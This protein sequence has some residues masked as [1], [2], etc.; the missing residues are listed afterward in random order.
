MSCPSKPRAHPVAGPLLTL[1]LLSVLLP[2]EKPK[3]T[4]EFRFPDVT[5]SAGL[6][7][8]H[9]TGGFG[10]KYLPETMGS[11]CLFVD[12][13]NDGWPEILALNGSDLA[14]PKG[15]TTR[16]AYYRNNRDGTFI[17]VTRAAGLGLDMY[18]MGATAGDFDNDGDQDIYITC[19]GPDHLFQNQ[20]NGTFREITAGAGLGNPDFGASA[21]WLD[22]DRD[23]WLDLYV[24]NYVQW[25]PATDIYC[26]LDGKNKSYCT[27]E[28]YQGVSGR[29]YR[30]LQG[31]RFEDVTR[32]AGLFLPSQKGLGVCVTDL[33][34]DG[35]P[36]IVVANDTQ[37][38]NVFLNGRNG[39]FRDVGVPSGVAFSEDGV[40]RGAMGIDAAD[41]DLTGRQSLLIGNFSNQ[42]LALY[43][44]EGNVFF[45][46]EAP[47]SEV[48]HRSLLTLAFGCFFFDYDLDGLIDI[49]VANGHV[50]N[51]INKVQAK[52][53]YAQPPHLFRNTGGRAFREVTA[54][55]GPDLA[56]PYVARGAAFADYDR[57][58]DLDILITTNGGPLH[59][60]MNE[61]GSPKNSL[62]L[63]LQGS[64]SNRNGYGSLLQVSVGGQTSTIFT[65]SS[66]SYLSQSESTWT[67]GLG[68]RKLAE[69]VRVAWPSGVVQEF[70]NLAAGKEYVIHEEK[71]ISIRPAPVH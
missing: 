21:A 67:F 2:Q 7:F 31:K 32:K 41:Y 64:R 35:W 27:P 56:R 47:V 34:G 12:F 42:M 66:S 52:V 22:Y 40:A 25:T 3:N 20:G 4:P 24:C 43:H 1:A 69:K 54:T 11:G 29:L 33:D 46:D 18:A 45:I 23:G 15:K 58:G 53:T 5:A 60:F 19:L 13:D 10:K 6:R 70:Q 51:E 44:N 63:F 68:D 37:P 38:N 28:S 48:G 14:T 9:Y 36:D 65:R 59:L 8:T 30:N 71:G 26:T 57:D 49:F 39:T 61:S 17:D 55:A 16:P 62:R 50:E